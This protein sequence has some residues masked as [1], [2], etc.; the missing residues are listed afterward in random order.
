[1]PSESSLSK[2]TYAGLNLLF[3][4]LILIAAFFYLAT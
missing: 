1:M 3:G 2:A 4:V